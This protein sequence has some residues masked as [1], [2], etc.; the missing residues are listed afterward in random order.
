[1]T[2]CEGDAKNTKAEAGKKLYIWL[3]NIDDAG[4]VSNTSQDNISR[5]TCP[6]DMFKEMRSPATVIEDANKQN[7]FYGHEELGA[8]RSIQEQPRHT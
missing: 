6:K 1:M 3:L 8:C 4:D 5:D 7:D 2:T